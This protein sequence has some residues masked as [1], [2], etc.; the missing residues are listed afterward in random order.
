MKKLFT[1]M[2]MALVAMSANAKEVLTLPDDM[3]PG[4]TTA[5]GNWAWRDVAKLYSGAD[6]ADDATDAGVVYYD[7]SAYDYLV[8]KYKE[9]TVKTSFG[10]Q[11][12]SKG[13]VGQWGP[14][15]YASSGE[16]AANTSGILG[17]KL[18]ADHKN[19][20]YKVYLQSQGE[21]SLVVEEVYFG[22]TAEYEAD[23]AANPVTPYVAPT[24]ALNLANATNKWGEATYDA[25]THTA[26]IDKDDGASGWWVNGISGYDYLV[27]EILD[28]QKVGYAQLQQLPDDAIPL[29][30][31]SFVKVIDISNMNLTSGFN[32]VIQGGA[33]TTWK[34]QAVYFATAEYVQKNNIKDGPIYSDTQDIALSG[35]NP[36]KDGETARA[37]FDATTGVLTI[38]DPTDGGAG[39]WVSPADYSHFDNFV[40]ELES[41]TAGGAV[42]VQYGAEEAAASRRAN[43]QTKVEF[44]TGAT[45]VVVPLTAAY[46]NNVQQMWIQG[47]S[48]ATYTLKKA[49]VAV[50]SATPEANLGTIEGGEESTSMAINYA[51][52][53]AGD[54]TVA[55][56]TKN[57]DESTDTK[58][59]YDIKGGEE[60]QFTLNTAPDVVFTI[61]NG[62]D[63]QKVFIVNVNDDETTDKGSVEFGGKNG[64]VIFKDA[65]V[66]DVIKM[67]VAAKGGTA[68]TIGVLPSSGNDLI[69]TTKMTL[70]KK[71]KE[72]D[73][74]DAEGYVWKEFSFTVTEDMIKTLDGVKVVRVKETAGG[75]RCK[76]ISIN[77]DLPTGIQ[78]VK[79]ADTKSVNGAIYNLAGQKVNETYKG[80]V[81]KDGKKYI[82]K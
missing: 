46:K 65:K 74:A 8:I 56:A 82:Q 52:M 31:G 63:K 59:V 49:Y 30:E 9:C 7:A 22:S 64:V 16:I 24:M 48:G 6:I 60:L 26:T 1:L 81:I 23:L 79:A 12:N 3:G 14:E 20:V 28:L 58:N 38:T 5:F 73:D 62:N 29:D 40:I 41:T 75:Y 78:S 50:A 80:I 32:L 17:V 11:Y 61:T 71:D 43:A 19:K 51:E 25:E 72:N 53:K 57:A 4:K 76:A 10:V 66:D 15:L 67:V 33:G 39:W 13:T 77:A 68:A 45:C 44:G 27:L 55:N 70:P 47:N 69:E 21:G 36:W 18:D 35:L 42:V 54:F 37:T 34:W 2:V